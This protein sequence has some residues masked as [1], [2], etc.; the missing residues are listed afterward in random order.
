MVE[1][2]FFIPITF[3]N[4]LAAC[5]SNKKYII[6]IQTRPTKIVISIFLFNNPVFNGFLKII[7][8]LN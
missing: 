7:G 3:I 4:Q 5:F 6:R 8:E 2:L 1:N